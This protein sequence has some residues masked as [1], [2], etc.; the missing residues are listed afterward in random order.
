MRVTHPRQ[1]VEEAWGLESHGLR[2]ME[3]YG[4]GSSGDG[5]LGARGSVMSKKGRWGQW[6]EEGGEKEAEGRETFSRE[7]INPPIRPLGEFIHRASQ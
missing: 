1:G 6:G 3:V 4:Q 7:K 5:G 2:D